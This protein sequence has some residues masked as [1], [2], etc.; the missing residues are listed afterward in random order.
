MSGENE[1]SVLRHFVALGVGLASAALAFLVGFGFPATWN[2]AAARFEG[3][4]LVL[5]IVLGTSVFFLGCGPA[6]YGAR[7]LIAPDQG[8]S[9]YTHDVH[10]QRVFAGS[11][12]W[13]VSRA[14]ALG[15][16]AFGWIYAVA[17]GFVFL[18]GGR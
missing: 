6:L 9:E 3:R 11:V 14:S 2:G 16:L 13:R 8:R 17:I 12:R 10:G 1:S 7:G 18:R 4:H 5:S 15:W